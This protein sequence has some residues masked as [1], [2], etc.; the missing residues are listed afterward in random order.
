MTVEYF[1][2]DGSALKHNVY[3]TNTSGSTETFRVLQR[4]A[5]IVGAKCNGKDFPLDTDE[6]FLAFHKADE[7][8]AIAENLHSMIFNPD[9]SEK[10]DQ[11]LQRPIKIESHA[12]GMKTDF[13]YGNWPLSTGESLVIDPDTVTKQV[14][15]STDDAGL[16]GAFAAWSLDNRELYLGFGSYGRGWK[17]GVIFRNVT[18]PKGST[19]QNA[20]LQYCSYYTNTESPV[21]MDIIGIDE[22]DCTT[23]STKA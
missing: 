5:G 21:N 13:V 15:A 23:F 7:K 1:Q 16:D 11:C 3:F 2:R 19:I 18:I 22:D 10:I 9:G 20:V 14:S 12:Q 17:S 4:W 6:S 8:L